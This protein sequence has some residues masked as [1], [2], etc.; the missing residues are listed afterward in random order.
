ML[1]FRVKN[2]V[3]PGGQYFY[4]VEGVQLTM[5]SRMKLRE[6]VYQVYRKAQEAVPDNLE[7]LM[8][9]YMCR[10]LPE[11]FCTGTDDGRPRAKV[12]TI[13]GIRRDTENMVSLSTGFAPPTKSKFN[14][15]KCMSC[16]M[17]NRNMCTTCSGV[18]AWASR[19][20]GRPDTPAIFNW[21]GICEVDVTALAAKVHLEGLPNND[22]YPDTCWVREDA[23]HDD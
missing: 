6:A 10:R 12:A 9:D 7:A 3:P 17:N 2:I 15:T 20:V 23:N 14:A 4:E 13:Q 21:L 18:N 19:R 11:G 22:E 1:N 16:P 8:E 5:P